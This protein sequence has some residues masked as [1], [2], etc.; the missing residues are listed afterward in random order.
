RSRAG[1]RAAPTP[2]RPRTSRARRR[3]A[4]SADA[5]ASADPRSP[6]PAASRCGS[7]RSGGIPARVGH[8]C[9][10]PALGPELLG[11]LLGE[12]SLAH[13]QVEELVVLPLP[14]ALDR[15]DDVE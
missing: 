1:R 7:S 6:G 10:A 12:A 8:R 13:A 5:W 15:D 3:R 14:R 11:L 2:M 4:A 9:D